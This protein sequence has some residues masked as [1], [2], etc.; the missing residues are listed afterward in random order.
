MKAKK[1]VISGELSEESYADTVK[2]NDVFR[3]AMEELSKLKQWEFHR[4]CA[5]VVY[6]T[7]PVKGGFIRIDAKRSVYNAYVLSAGFCEE[8]HY[9]S[10]KVIQNIFPISDS[11]FKSFT[12][13]ISS[14]ILVN[15]SVANFRLNE[16]INLKAKELEKCPIIQ[17]VRKLEDCHKFNFTCG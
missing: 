8:K 5:N 3:N 2:N 12:L 11:G 16:L 13:S 10:K 7:T 15:S 4:E 17:A 1:T 9:V 14:W 6:W